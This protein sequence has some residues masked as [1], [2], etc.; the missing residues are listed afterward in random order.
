M[1]AAWVRR[2][3]RGDRAALAA[4][5]RAHQDRVYRFLL[6]LSADPDLALDLAQETFIRAF[7][8]LGTFRAGASLNPWLFKIAHRLFLDHVRAKRPTEPLD[9]LL[10][11]EPG[12][13]DPAIEGLADA[14]AVNAALAKL[15]VNWREA[16]VLRHF[17]D[18]EYETI[19]EILEVPVGTVKTWLHRGRDRLRQELSEGR[20]A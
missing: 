8:A 10:A 9:E 20:P 6:R 3:A 7:G 13:L 19:A 15:P 4:I 11:A 1:E 18:L 16:L 2:G 12:S 5:V 17:H 14:E